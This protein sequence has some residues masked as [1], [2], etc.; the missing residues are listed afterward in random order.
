MNR[1]TTSATHARYRALTFPSIPG[2]VAPRALVAPVAFALGIHLVLVLAIALVPGRAEAGCKAGA[3]AASCVSMQF[4]ANATSVIDPVGL[5]GT[6]SPTISGT[7]T[8]DTAIADSDPDPITGEYLLSVD[9]ASI[10]FGVEVMDLN[11]GALSAIDESFVAVVNDLPDNSGPFPVLT[12]LI[13]HGIGALVDFSGMMGAG[14]LSYAYSEFC[15]VG[16]TPCPPTIASS[17]AFPGAPGAIGTSDLF[18][19]QFLNLIGDQAVVN[20]QL[21]SLTSVPVVPCPEPGMGA[22]LAGGVFALA[23]LQR[24]RLHCVDKR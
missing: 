11:L 14:T 10:D 22:A 12:D 19:I 21:T 1:R 16:V 24:R 18:L 5:L 9:C 3:V 15:I 8:F 6:V 20:G 23:A 13:S 17:D 2:R 4:S 7:M